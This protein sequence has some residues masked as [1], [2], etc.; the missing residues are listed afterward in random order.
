MEHYIT[1]IIC[2]T[3]QFNVPRE[4]TRIIL[5]KI[6]TPS[7][8]KLISYDDDFISELPI[9]FIEELRIIS[10]FNEEFQHNYCVLLKNTDLILPVINY[11]LSKNY[12]RNVHIIERLQDRFGINFQIIID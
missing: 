10:N 8:H 5:N 3:N 12:I 9:E 6:L 4:L 1:N 7:Y 11:G 2:I